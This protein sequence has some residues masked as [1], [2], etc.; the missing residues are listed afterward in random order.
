MWLE[1]PDLISPKV[2][3][4]YTYDNICR[5]VHRMVPSHHYSMVH[6]FLMTSIQY[7]EPRVGELLIE[8]LLSKNEE[9]FVLTALSVKDTLI[10]KIRSSY[11]TSRELMAALDHSVELIAKMSPYNPKFAQPDEPDLVL[12]FFHL[13]AFPLIALKSERRYDWDYSANR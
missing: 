4:K 3:G 7:L 12:S 5:M 11:S 9:W 2:C 8:D 13:P 1:N 10:A 6:N